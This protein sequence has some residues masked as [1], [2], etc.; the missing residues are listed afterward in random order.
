MTKPEHDLAA[1]K[2]A[3]R[4]QWATIL[5]AVGGVAVDLL[6]GKNHPCPRCGG[7]DRFR[8][9]NQDD[10]GSCYCNQCFKGGGDG[11]A[12]LQWLRG[13]TFPQAVDALAAHLG[14]SPWP[15]GNGK[16]RIVATY[17]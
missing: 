13:G 16:A 1:L 14:H 7:E 10:D 9:T 3:A 15:A 12:A 4:G 5:A 17:D 8:F 11:I 6:D 2:E